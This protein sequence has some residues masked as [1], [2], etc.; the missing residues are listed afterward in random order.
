VLRLVLAAVVLAVAAETGFARESSLYTVSNVEVDVSDKNASAAK[1]KAI[2]EAQVKA[3]KILAERLGGQEAVTA[4]AYLTESEIGRMM[5]SLSIQS[6]KSAPGRYIGKLSIAFLPERVRAAFAELG[7]SY[8][9]DRPPRIVIL[10]VWNGPEGPVVW[11]DNPWRKAWL[12]LN[13]EDDLL[14]I[15]VP[16]GDLDDSETISAQEALRGNEVKLESLKLRYEAESVLVAVAEPE[17]ETSVHAIMSGESPWGVVS[18][19]KVYEGEDG[20]LERAADIA[21]ERFVALINEKWKAADVAD[22]EEAMGPLQTVAVTVPFSSIGQW[23]GIRAQLLSVTGVASV[24]VTTMASGGAHI[25]LGFTT[26]FPV[27]QQSLAVVGMKL[28]EIRGNWVLQ[29]L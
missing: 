1:L 24:D 10:P 2:S 28:V 27:L 16:L 17:G 25:R 15:I 6:E 12:G 22:A 7:V 4:V 23:N 14:P 11:E 8:L 21:A 19:D 9:E 3:F 29:P 20:G 13:S 26:Q 18:L 5:S